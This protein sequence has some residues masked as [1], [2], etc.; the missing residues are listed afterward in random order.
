MEALR[1]E[2]MLKRAKE[3]AKEI[4]ERDPE[5]ENYPLLKQKLEKMKEMIHLE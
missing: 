4:L 3:R 5:L 1:N 2:E